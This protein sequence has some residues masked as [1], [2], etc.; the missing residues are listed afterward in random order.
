[1]SQPISNSHAQGLANDEAVKSAALK[2][3]LDH[4]SD[5]RE[6]ET[7]TN[8]A[9]SQPANLAA[10]TSSTRITLFT[11]PKPFGND[12]H[13]DMIQRNAI[14][15]WLQ[16]APAIEVVMLGD[17][18]GIADV[19]AELG[20]VH[21]PGLQYNDRGTPIVSSA[22]KLVREFS[23]RPLLAYC[24]SDVILLNDFVQGIDLIVR[25]GEFENFLAFGRRT[26]LRVDR[27]INF[28]SLPE[29]KQLVADSLNSGVISSQVCKEYFVFT[30]SMFEDMPP[31]AIGR[32]NWDNWIIHHAKSTKTPVVNVSDLVTVIHQNHDYQHTG[33]G[34][35]KC[36]VSG[37]EAKANESLGGGRHLI[38]GSVGTWRLTPGGLTRERPLLLNRA[39]WADVPRFIRLLGSLLSSR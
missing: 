18:E 38:S 13:T 35:M 33:Q 9:A 26:D 11:V 19:A 3:I 1:M 12:S 34:R 39:F 28:S 2:V 27:E 4:A 7:P 25:T 31:F 15:S 37:E 14:R 16:L 22:F 6:R 23:T 24:N 21:L 36:Y 10:P 20:A 8:F 32:G 17:E 30:P 29:T 5:P